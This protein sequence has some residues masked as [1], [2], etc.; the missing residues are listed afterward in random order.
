MACIK[1]PAIDD[2]SQANLVVSDIKTRRIDVFCKINQQAAL[3]VQSILEEMKK[4]GVSNGKER[5]VTVVI[6]SRGGEALQGLAIYDLLRSSGFRIRTIALGE[7]ASSGLAIMLAG[8]ERAMYRNAILNFHQTATEFEIGKSIRVLRQ[9]EIEAERA[10]TRIVDAL[11]AKI[12]LENSRISLRQLK[13]LERREA[14]VT[15][16][17][18]LKMGFVHELIEHFKLHAT[19]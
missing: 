7:V 6:N 15:A 17:Q 10:Q 3:H 14:Y 8:H 1:S 9:G 18:A 12:T 16:E 11:Y 5:K 13:A 19:P 4:R 2:D